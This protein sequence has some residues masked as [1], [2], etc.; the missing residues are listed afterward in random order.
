MSVCAGDNAFRTRLTGGTECE[1]TLQADVETLK[2][3]EDALR[4]G[5]KTL[6]LRQMRLEG[7]MT[8]SCFRVRERRKGGTAQNDPPHTCS[9]DDEAP[10]WDA[11]VISA[12]CVVK[13]PSLSDAQHKIEKREN[14]LTVVSIELRYVPRIGLGYA[15]PGAS[16]V[17]RHSVREGGDAQ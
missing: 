5:N 15:L 6:R 9:L 10:F 11:A 13:V 3:D 8:T 16:A 14:F 12:D 4:E 17:T 2:E 1:D 7:Q